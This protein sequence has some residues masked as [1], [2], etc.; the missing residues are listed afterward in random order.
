M[1]NILFIHQSADLYGSDKTLLFL[2]DSIR[3]EV[4]PIVVVP[5]EGPLTEEFNKKNIEYI[6][7][8]VIKVSR[9]F[10]KG[11][12]LLMLPF[13]IY[14]ALKSLRKK[15]EG[16]KIDVIHSNTLA[17]LLGGIYSKRYNIKH[18]WHIHE[19]I[20]KPKIV[21]KAY[22]PLVNF[23]SDKVVFNSNASAKHL[24]KNNSKLE[25]KSIV[26]YNGL[27]RDELSI[28]S[29]ER[30]LLRESL[31]S[32][33]N[34]SSIVI[35]LV[36]RINKHKGQQ[37]MLNVFHQLQQEGQKNIYLL[38]IGSTIPTQNF[39]LKE[40]KEMI[41]TKELIDSVKIINFQ[42]EIWKFYDA[43]DIV[44]VPTLDPE[45]FGLVAVEGMLARK[46]IIASNHGGLK[47][48]VIHHKTGLLFEPNNNPELK[49][50]IETLIQ[51]NTL[52]E[53]YGIEGEKRAKTE[54]SLNN[55]IDNFKTF[56]K[57]LYR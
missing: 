24:Y 26:I 27:D 33:I 31:F 46:P 17:V 37:M 52:M 48:I 45:P 36:G 55:Y 9:K 16:R 12:H 40:L 56:Y 47:E 1:R 15:I 7:S 53:V 50:S 30:Q 8:P 14:K 3:D 42:K 25:K 38:F 19:I 13:T 20:K 32:S 39:L 35:G 34:D 11:F 5:E 10:F 21:A 57:N 29:K 51:N 43:L 23:F 18:V 44:V 4:N 54:F 49:K 22:P 6:I 41:K 28:S 2:V